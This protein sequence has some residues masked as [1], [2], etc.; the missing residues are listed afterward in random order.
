MSLSP[1]L[2]F[3]ASAQFDHETEKWYHVAALLRE[4]G[5]IEFYSDFIYVDKFEDPKLQCVDVE[6]AGKKFVFR[7]V[8]D[9][10]KFSQQTQ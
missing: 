5:R 4:N 3:R 6:A 2:K 7:L 9:S 1:I 8:K 10:D